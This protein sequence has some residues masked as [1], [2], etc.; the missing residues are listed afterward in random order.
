ME[1]SW[2][3]PRREK[4][5]VSMSHIWDPQTSPGNVANCWICSMNLMRKPK[6]SPW[7]Y[8]VEIMLALIRTHQ[9]H[10]HA[11]ISE[12]V[13]FGSYHPH[14][15]GCLKKH[16]PHCKTSLTWLLKKRTLP[17]LMRCGSTSPN[18]RIGDVSKQKTTLNLILLIY[19]ET[20]THVKTTVEE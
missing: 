20:Q 6:A 9:F 15:A 7:I 5:N 11:Y 1:A 19:F 13:D 4:W 10:V 8:E 2:K 16:L 17:A 18:L 12:P 3:H 14:T